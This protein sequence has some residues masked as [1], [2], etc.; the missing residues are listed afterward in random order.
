MLI[1]NYV[2]IVKFSSNLVEQRSTSGGISTTNAS[3]CNN[4]NDYMND[5]EMESNGHTTNG[6]N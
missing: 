4:D 5:V 2:N 1:S 6:E 3:K